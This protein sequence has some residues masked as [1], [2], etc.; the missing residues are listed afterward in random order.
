MWLDS[1]SSFEAKNVNYVAIEALWYLVKW[2]QKGLRNVE[3]SLK[4]SLFV[5][6]ISFEAIDCLRSKVGLV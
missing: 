3:H 4:T 5:H 1:L 6:T 2:F